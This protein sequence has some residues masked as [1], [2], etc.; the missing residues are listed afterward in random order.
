MRYRRRGPLDVCVVVGGARR[1][2]ALEPV[3]DKEATCAPPEGSHVQEEYAEDGG[4]LSW[5]VRV[6]HLREPQT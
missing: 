1:V 2:Q 6:V 3:G 4:H 5:Y